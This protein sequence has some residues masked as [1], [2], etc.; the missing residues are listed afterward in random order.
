MGKSHFDFNSWQKE[1][2]KKTNNIH[3]KLY[4]KSPSGFLMRLYRNMKS[5]VAGIQKKDKPYWVG[6]DLVDKESFYQWASDHPKF[7]ELYE[8]YVSS[9]YVRNLAPSVDRVD[10][11]EGYTFS[12]MEWVTSR[13]NCSRSAKLR[14]GTP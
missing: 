3:T 9:G 10:S 1:Y 8:E 5:R 4:E 11:S 6:K 13:E 2:R 14:W 7:K 12:N